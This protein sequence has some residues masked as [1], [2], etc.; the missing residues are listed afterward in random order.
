[1]VGS[2]IAEVGGDAII[3]PFRVGPQRRS[4]KT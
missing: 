2:R 1:M 3:Y 4:W